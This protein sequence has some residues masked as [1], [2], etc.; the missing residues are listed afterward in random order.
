VV[1]HWLKWL[2][3]L[4]VGFLVMEAVR[5]WFKHRN[6][7][8]LLRALRPKRG[9]ES[10]R[11]LTGRPDRGNEFARTDL[12]SVFGGKVDFS[13]IERILAPA[14]SGVGRKLANGGAL[15]DSVSQLRRGTHDRKDA[16]FLRESVVL[17]YASSCSGVDL[18]RTSRERG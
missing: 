2:L 18:Q 15:A 7:A 9:T 17:R 14:T 4:I 16:G 1:P 11:P 13:K 6:Y 10:G 8:A 12:S 5:Y 3:A